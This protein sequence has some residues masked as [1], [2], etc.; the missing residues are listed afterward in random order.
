MRLDSNLTQAVVMSAGIAGCGADSS[1]LTGFGIDVVPDCFSG[2]DEL[3]GE[4]V[5]EAGNPGGS[6]LLT[7]NLGDR[8]NVSGS[9]TFP[10]CL[11][12]TAIKGKLKDSGFDI[13]TL[14][15]RPFLH[16]QAGRY[17]LTTDGENGC[18]LVDTGTVSFTR[19]ASG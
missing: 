9:V 3:Q 5:S 6:I 13:Q 4:A 7:R 17:T 10:P 12:V 18:P 19:I 16:I 1:V 15:P 2:I 11:P 14:G 8:C